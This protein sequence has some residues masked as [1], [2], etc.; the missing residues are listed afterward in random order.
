[1]N[2][3]YFVVYF[4]AV[5]LSSCA[6]KVVQEQTIKQPNVIL[7]LTDDQG[8]GDFSINRNKVLKTPH[9]DK[10]ANNG[11]LLERFYV[12]P[13]CAPTRASLLTGRYHLRTGVSWVTGGRENMRS[14][15]VTI[16]EVL[17]ENGYATGAFGKWHNGAHYPENPQGQG[18]DTFFGFT[19]GHLSNYF[20][21][22]LEYNGRQVRTEGYI[23]DVL[24]NA[25]LS[26][27]DQH[28][29]EPFFAFV[30]FNAPHTPYQ[31]PDK[32]Y[33]QFKDIDYG[34]G[35]KQNKKIATIYGMCKNIDDNLGRI[36]DHLKLLKIEENTIVLFLSDNGPQGAR[37]NG[38]WRGGKTSVHE[39][40]SLVPMA[41]QWKGHIPTGTKNAL[42]AH[43]D[44][45]PT[46][47]ALLGIEHDAK[48]FDGIDIANYILNK[49][50]KIED[51]KLYTHMAGFE[52]T[53]DRGAV[54]NNEYR[55]TIENGVTGL[56]NLSIDPSEN[57]NIKNIFPKKAEEMQLSFDTWYEDVTSAGFADL[58]I[59]IGYNESPR[60]QLAA[61]EGV[62]TGKIKYKANPNGWAHD[63]F[64][65]TGNAQITW[66]IEIISKGEYSMKLF[67]TGDASIIGTEIE[68]SCNNKQL[69]KVIEKEFITEEYPTP[70]RVL[71]EQEA[72]E[73]TWGEIDIGALSFDTTFTSNLSIKIKN[74]NS[75]PL[76]IKGLQITKSN[77]YK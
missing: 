52:I 11:T 19:A 34:Y 40:G 60:T 7:I 65:S 22:E 64:V 58:R 75:N 50:D 38:V 69:S 6:T 30:P 37:F 24:T 43:I 76:E 77:N 71:R 55:Y 26:F 18:F 25:T 16:A 35:E 5:L 68:V 4:C 70:D 63:W 72:K 47:L 39:G 27:I 1:M 51:R 56:Y 66:P 29:D 48:H 46:L 33:N 57:E 2:K 20:D 44:V 45:M 17:K 54:R 31:V 42:T 61:H 74:K 49:E 10:M 32:Y 23:T 73:Q 15:E 14:E 53:K 3:V 12:S 21:S 13:V 28:K 41:L 9:F 59:P 8:W 67:Y 62:G 36:L